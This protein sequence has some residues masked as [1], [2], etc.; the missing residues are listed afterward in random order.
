MHLQIPFSTQIEFYFYFKR[1]GLLS[2]PPDT[3]KH[4]YI[5]RKKMESSS[6]F[7]PTS[8]RFDASFLSLL[9][10]FV[11]GVNLFQIVW[12]QEIAHVFPFVF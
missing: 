11:I 10:I 4:T 8:Q 2:F 3:H 1:K 12:V 7:H 5:L 9:N 6:G